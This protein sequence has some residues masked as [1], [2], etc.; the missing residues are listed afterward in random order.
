MWRT[1]PPWWPPSVLSTPLRT[2]IG[3]LATPVMRWLF[4][5]YKHSSRYLCPTTTSLYLFPLQTHLLMHIVRIFIYVKFVTGWLYWGGQSLEVSSDL[6]DSHTYFRHRPF[7]HLLSIN[8]LI[9]FSLIN[10]VVRFRQLLTIYDD[11][12]L[13]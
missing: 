10:S 9:S 3:F 11:K 2:A 13:I 7:F 4:R 1:H 8:F 6:V 12:K 5:V